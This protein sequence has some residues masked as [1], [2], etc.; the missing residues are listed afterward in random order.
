MLIKIQWWH[1]NVEKM[2][3]ADALIEIVYNS[4]KSFNFWS[5]ES[6]NTQS[7]IKKVTQSF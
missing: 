7:F 4:M 2:F 6:K 5:F 1:E 3:I